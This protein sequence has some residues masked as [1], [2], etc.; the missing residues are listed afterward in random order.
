MLIFNGCVQFTIDTFIIYLINTFII[1]M[2]ILIAIL[3]KY[4]I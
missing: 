4:N 3:I 2:I 1:Y